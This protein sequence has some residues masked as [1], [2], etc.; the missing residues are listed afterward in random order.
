MDQNAPFLFKDM[1]MWT[2][3]QELDVS[4][5]HLSTEYVIHLMIMYRVSL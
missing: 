1:L 5:C 3:V 2:S 4:L